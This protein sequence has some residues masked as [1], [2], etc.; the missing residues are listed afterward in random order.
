MK[1]ALKTRANI[2]NFVNNKNSNKSALKPTPG[3]KI[4]SL[5]E[6]WNWEN[7]DPFVIQH[8]SETLAYK[9]IANNYIVKSC[10]DL[11]RQITL[12][13]P[14]HFTIDEQQ[15]N[16][17]ADE[18]LEFVE[19]TLTSIKNN[20][21]NMLYCM[22]DG[23]VYGFFVAEKIFI[24]EN[25]K[26]ILEEI[27]FHKPEYFEFIRDIYLNLQTLRYSGESGV[28]DFENPFT[29][30][31]IGTYPYLTQGN[32]YGVS[33]Y[34]SIRNL[35]TEYDNLT[36]MLD[37]G[38][39]FIACKPII[40][41]FAVDRDGEEINQSKSVVK[42][43]DNYSVAHLPMKKLMGT[44]KEEYGELDKLV[45]L[46]D[47]ASTEGL[48]QLKQQLDKKEKNIRHSLGVPDDLGF[49][50]TG[51]GSYAK[52]K[53]Q[54]SLLVSK[55]ERMQFWLE[56]I[57]NNQIIKQLV[58]L[59]YPGFGIYPK[60]FFEE[61]EEEVTTEKVNNI[62]TLIDARV[63][64][65]NEEWIRTDYLILPE[66]EEIEEVEQMEIPIT[67][68]TTQTNDNAENDEIDESTN[69]ED[70]DEDKNKNKN[71]FQTQLNQ[72]KIADYKPLPNDETNY[73]FIKTGFDRIER[74]SSNNLSTLYK[75]LMIET[76]NR[77]PKLVQNP[78]KMNDEKLFPVNITNSVNWEYEKSLV[79][80]YVL[81]KQEANQILTQK[82]K[83]VDNL[84][85]KLPAHYFRDTTSVTKY[86]EKIIKNLGIQLTKTDKESL[87]MAIQQSNLT[88]TGQINNLERQVR[89]MLLSNTLVKTGEIGTQG[90]AQLS[91]KV[92]EIF[93]PFI[94]TG[95]IAG[96]AAEPYIVETTIKTMSAQYFNQAR[97]N[98]FN[99]PEY[100]SLISAF[101]Y[102]ALLDDRTTEICEHLHGRIITADDS[103]LSEYNPPNHFN[104]R[105]LFI[106]ILIGE[107]YK[108]NWSTTIKPQKGF[109]TI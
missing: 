20:F 63:I 89:Q 16:A 33:E 64:H 94:K 15:K 98:T 93:S 60:F 100:R 35:V 14:Y 108:P 105:S 13:T 38:L 42:Q 17:R 72:G 22:L 55:V 45:V 29:S 90:V 41:Y 21:K 11:L 50:D 77:I 46:D 99:E 76:I 82:G 70:K 4:P 8:G 88:T 106:P 96:K 78:T 31:I 12:I 26:Y 69:D 103:S 27:K 47:R 58:D 51:V 85:N 24:I 68:E 87:R 102:S 48:K 79:N 62:K 71:K 57:I 49:T 39:Q 81:G 32:Y 28:I 18:V 1:L 23:R 37:K 5:S 86:L 43:L 10:E 54:G 6:M 91:A 30:F 53:E 61:T 80:S 97:M 74:E 65:P 73:A 84:S 83:R 56:D 34:Q 36:A 67:T 2:I 52:A 75:T 107:S 101:E 66:K 92:Q 3:N 9:P 59:N 40:H 7:T 25:G 109:D 19:T 95:V 44:T 104:C